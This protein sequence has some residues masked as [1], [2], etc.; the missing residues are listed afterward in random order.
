MAGEVR[1]CSSCAEKA[2]FV[3]RESGT[4]LCSRHLKESVETR[5]LARILQ[6]GQLP[7]II[8]VAFSGGKDSTALLAALAN[9][10]EKIPVRLIALTVD[11]GINGYRE[12]TISHAREVCTI[13]GVEHRIITFSE[14]YGE[15]LD[16][17]MRT[18]NRKACTVCGIL[19][20]RALEVLAEKEGIRLIATGH[21]QD[22][23]AQTT[24]M[25][26]LSADIKKVFAGS[27]HSTRFAHRI[28]PFAAVSER[29]ASLYAIL[30]GLFNDLPE[31]PYA[32]DALRGEIRMLLNQFEQEHPGSMRNLA[33]A[34]EEIR[35]RLRDKVEITPLEN[36]R[37]CGWPGSGEICQ[38]CSLIKKNETR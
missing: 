37:I 35:T 31:C 3:D 18:T 33:Q 29:E 4:H 10:K 20:R 24:L 30:A 26:A 11:E 12:E 15:T 5:V 32:G 34:E 36:C 28:K 9:L 25:N 21:N 14:I 17:I 2:V 1:T 22:D 38:V 19:R 16:E 8:G 27:G 6:E 7:G 13:L 23:H